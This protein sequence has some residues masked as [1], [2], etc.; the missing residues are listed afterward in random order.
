MKTTVQDVLRVK[1]HHIWSISPDSWVYE[2]L[3]I[4]A[5][6]NV[7]ALAVIDQGGLAGIISERDYARK[8]VLKGKSS[9]QTPVRDIMTHDV[10]HVRP[11]QTIEECMVVMT[12]NHVRHLPVLEDDRL[13]GI[14]SIGD[15]VKAIIAEKEFIIGQLENYITGPR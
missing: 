13:V 14:I 7:G 9:L 8:V 1:G 4:M 11:E 5:D 6:K 12:E 10:I 3:T 15:V 2:A